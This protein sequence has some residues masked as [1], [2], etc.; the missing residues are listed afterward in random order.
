MEVFHS[1]ST[2][3]AS[4]GLSTINSDGK[5]EKYTVPRSGFVFEPNHDG[6]KR[7]FEETS[8]KMNHRHSSSAI[9]LLSKNFCVTRIARYRDD[10]RKC[11]QIALLLMYRTF[12]R[13]YDRWLS[14]ALRRTSTMKVSFWLNGIRPIRLHTG[15]RSLSLV[16]GKGVVC[17]LLRMMPLLLESNN[18]PPTVCCT[19]RTVPV[20]IMCQLGTLFGE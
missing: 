19:Y 8:K 18:R 16:D 5:H 13:Y 20:F 10:V 12:V 3:S 6:D 14:G 17:C 9:S 7:C 1:L 15:S 2:A 4:Q 11:V